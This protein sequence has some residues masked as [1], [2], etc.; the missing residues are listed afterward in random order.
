MIH[1]P[2]RTA[3]LKESAVPVLFVMGRHDVAV[4]LQDGLKQCHLPQLSYIHILENAGHMGMIEEKEAA[5]RILTQ[6]VNAIEN[7]A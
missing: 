3:V 7:T 6:F 2:D 1:R 5:N 4:P